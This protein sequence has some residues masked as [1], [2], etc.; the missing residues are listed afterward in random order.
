MKR[1][2]PDGTVLVP[3]KYSNEGIWKEAVNNNWG[4][5]WKGWKGWKGPDWLKNWGYAPETP[6]SK[7]TSNTPK[8]ELLALPAPNQVHRTP[9]KEYINVDVSKDLGRSNL[10]GKGVIT[11]STPV[12]SPD[13]GT[14]RTVNAVSAIL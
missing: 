9:N 13:A 5:S 2:T 11:S 1:I 7:P 10:T 4:S 3:T 6:K 12:E 8:K 14:I